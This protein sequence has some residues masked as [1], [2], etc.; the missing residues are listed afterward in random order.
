VTA[1]SNRSK[2]NSACRR[3]PRNFLLGSPS[4]SFW[5]TLHRK[6][7]IIDLPSLKQIRDTC[8]VWRIES[9][10]G[11]GADSWSPSCSPRCFIIFSKVPRKTRKVQENQQKIGQFLRQTGT[12]ATRASTGNKAG[13]L[14]LQSPAPVGVRPRS[15]HRLS[16]FAPT[17]YADVGISGAKVIFT[18]VS[19][20]SVPASSAYTQ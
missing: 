3:M 20:Y 15:G 16:G 4:Y 10:L 18:T 12:D 11:F 13:R 2:R 17:A 6:D 8:N 9:S 19:R 14:A 5:V 1:W 7:L